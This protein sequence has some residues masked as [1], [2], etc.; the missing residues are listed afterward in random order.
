M[1]QKRMF[2][3]HKERHPVKWFVITL[4]LLLLS[5][6]SFGAGV[7]FATL[8]LE[9]PAFQMADTDKGSAMEASAAKPFRVA[10]KSGR[11]T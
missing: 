1:K 2:K 4:G 7:Q 8:T 10:H 5:L 9:G 6:A 3:R 11:D